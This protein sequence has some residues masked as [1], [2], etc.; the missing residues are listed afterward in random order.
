MDAGVLS[1][2]LAERR[3]Q[4]DAGQLIFIAHQLDICGRVGQV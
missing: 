4:I 2:W 1:S 3:R